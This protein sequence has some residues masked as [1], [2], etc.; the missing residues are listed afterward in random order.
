MSDRAGVAYADATAHGQAIQHDSGAVVAEAAAADP[1]TAAATDPSRPAAKRR[2]RRHDG[3]RLS[4][5]HR[6]PVAG[7]SAS[8]WLRADMP[9]AISGVGTPG[10]LREALRLHAPLLRPSP[11]HPVAV[12]GALD[13]AIVKAPK[14]GISRDRTQPTGRSAGQSGMS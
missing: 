6:V 3:H 7:H 13:S 1:A 2:P 8:V 10:R 9:S 4:A 5:P 11:R 12:G 14:G